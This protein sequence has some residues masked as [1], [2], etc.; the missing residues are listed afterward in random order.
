MANGNQNTYLHFMTIIF[1]VCKLYAIIGDIVDLGFKLSR[2]LSLR[3]HI[4]MI[5]SRVFK[6]LGFTMSLSK[7]FK[8]AK[9]LKSLNCA[10]VCPILAHNYTNR[11]H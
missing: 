1:R 10:L 6:V 2:T 11:Y 4:A 9:S 8:L 3:N 5:S 7:D